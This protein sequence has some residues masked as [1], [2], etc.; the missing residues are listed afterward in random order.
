MFEQVV[1]GVGWPENGFEKAEEEIAKGD[2]V[3][4]E[5]NERANKAQKVSAT[6]R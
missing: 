4:E 3:L 5:I 2:G 1:N 6:A